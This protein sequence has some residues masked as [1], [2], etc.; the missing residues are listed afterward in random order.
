MRCGEWQRVI[1]IP[2]A[3]RQPRRDTWWKT[4]GR[5]SS[6]DFLVV[7]Y[8]IRLTEIIVA[9]ARQQIAFDPF[10]DVRSQSVWYGLTG[11][12]PKPVRVKGPSRSL[13]VR[14]TFG[15]ANA[16][17]ARDFAIQVLGAAPA[18]DTLRDA[19]PG[20][21]KG[22]IIPRSG[23]RLLFIACGR[24]LVLLQTSASTADPGWVRTTCGKRAL[25]VG[26]LHKGTI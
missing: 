24:V 2:T 22:I 12:Q 1:S 26:C 8:N 19:L 25:G 5:I 7:A 13:T 6:E 23:R 4:S 21:R 10:S 17:L 14:S 18:G 16:S 3:A 11:L 9:L 20:S 15:V